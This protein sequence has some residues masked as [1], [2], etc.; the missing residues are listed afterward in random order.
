M[1]RFYLPFGKKNAPP[2]RH[3][4]KATRFFEKFP[5]PGGQASAGTGHR[6]TEAVAGHSRRIVKCAV[7]GEKPLCIPPGF[8]PDTQ[9]FQRPES[10]RQLGD[11]RTD[12]EQQRQHGEHTAER[13]WQ[14]FPAKRNTTRFDR[15]LKN[16]RSF[17]LPTFTSVENLA[18]ICSAS[19]LKCDI[20]AGASLID[21]YAHLYYSSQISSAQAMEQGMLLPRPDDF[22]SRWENI[23]EQGKITEPDL[24]PVFD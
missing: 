18:K 16:G 24:N 19:Q 9:L 7:Q 22:G 8:E 2:C 11:S 12:I 6:C 5:R 15:S 20:A 13:I 3:R 17:F 1:S 14:K 4:Q 10:I 23:T 21:G